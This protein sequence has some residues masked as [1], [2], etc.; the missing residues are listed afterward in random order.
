MEVIQRKRSLI[1][2]WYLLVQNVRIMLF[3]ATTC[4]KHQ[5]N[6]ISLTLKTPTDVTDVII[7]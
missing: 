1:P 2:S 3:K 4:S 5:N 6:V 7:F